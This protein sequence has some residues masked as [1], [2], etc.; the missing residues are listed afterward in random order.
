MLLGSKTLFQE[1]F[2]GLPSKFL[3]PRTRCH[4]FSTDPEVKAVS[5]RMQKL[6]DIDGRE[7]MDIHIYSAVINIHYWDSIITSEHA[8]ELIS[9]SK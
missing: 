3:E 8:D 2:D 4:V 9:R 5:L 7:V 1:A 6:K